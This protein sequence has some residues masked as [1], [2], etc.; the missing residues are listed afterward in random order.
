MPPTSNL[1]RSP[2]QESP[3]FSITLQVCLT[4]SLVGEIIRTW[5]VFSLTLTTCKEAIVKAPVLP[6]PDW[7]WAI[8]S[9]PWTIGLIA[10]LCI[11]VG[12]SNPFL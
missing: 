11:G 9:L 3:I 1:I 4:N 7:A 8:I 2:W 6:V 10:L 12:F 5:E